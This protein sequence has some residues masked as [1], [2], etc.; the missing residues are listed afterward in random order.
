MIRR[1]H[2]LLCRWGIHYPGQYIEIGPITR[3]SRFVILCKYCGAEES[4]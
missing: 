4:H 2:A 3:P 1:L